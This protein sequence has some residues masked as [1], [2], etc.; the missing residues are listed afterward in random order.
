MIEW[1]EYKKE[2]TKNRERARKTK[3]KKSKK[4]DK[5]DEEEEVVDDDNDE[6]KAA[7]RPMSWTD[8]AKVAQ[9]W[10]STWIKK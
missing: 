5:K 7:T 4:K 6:K 10:S 9:N 2:P 8:E 1:R 3:T